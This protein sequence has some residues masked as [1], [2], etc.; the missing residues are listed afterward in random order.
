MATTLSPTFFPASRSLIEMIIDAVAASG[1]DVTALE[2]K[3]K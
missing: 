3:S 2:E 1:L